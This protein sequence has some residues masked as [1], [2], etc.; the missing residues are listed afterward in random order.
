[1]VVAGFLVSLFTSC[2]GMVWAPRVGAAFF[3]QELPAAEDAV[4]A[5]RAAGKDRECP[6]D[7]KAVEKLKND[8]YTTYL[9][10]HTKEGIAMAVEASSKAAALCPARPRVEAKPAPAPAPAPAPPAPAP[11]APAPTVT[12]S[13]NPTSI[14]NGK[15]AT[16]TWST[17]D[18][19]TNKFD[20]G[21]G[22]VG[23]KGSQEV[24]PEHT[25]TYTL[26]STG[27]GGSKTETVTVTVTPRVVDRLTIHVNFDFNKSNIKKSEDAELQKAVDFLKK[28]KDYKISL[29]GYTDSIGSDAYNQKLSERRANSVKDYLVAHGAD[30]AKIEASGRGK[31]DPI[32]DNKTEDG[33]A[34][35][36]R[37][38]ILALE[39]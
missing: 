34:Q 16:L 3:P 6:D 33:R 30:A 13:A 8:A 4:A 39:E 25:T 36:R 14:E 17:T 32:A 15:C 38:E 28:N 19:K 35:N 24:C 26:T 29:V 10:C 27:E 21:L 31:A 20:K 1:M 5:A 22:A 2:S 9:A 23:P 11:S 37:V 18:A 12:L 7:F